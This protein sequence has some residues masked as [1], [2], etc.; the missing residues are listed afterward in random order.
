MQEIDIVSQVSDD[1]HVV[2]DK[3]DGKFLVGDQLTDKL[4]HLLVHG[5]RKGG[6]G[7]VQKKKS[8]AE[9]HDAGQGQKLLLAVGK[10]A[11]GLVGF[12]GEANEFQPLH[13]SLPAV[14]FPGLPAPPGQG[15]HKGIVAP[16]QEG[17]S[18]VLGHGKGREDPDVLEEAADMFAGDL[19]RRKAGD[20][21]AVKEDFAGI[22]SE[23]AADDVEE[24]RLAGAVRADQ[25]GD[26]PK[27]RGKAHIVQGLEGPETLGDVLDLELDGIYDAGIAI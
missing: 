20:V 23:I 12:V 14:L 4:D 3:G 21:L 18:D 26:L 25:S 19:V 24:R 17:D 15:R 16:V 1:A 27:G 11:G 13:G 7:L 6:C 22:R 10:L 2:L 9:R 8:W 5:R